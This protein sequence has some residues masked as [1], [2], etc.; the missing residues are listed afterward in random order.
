[1]LQTNNK[2]TLIFVCNNNVNFICF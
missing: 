2:N 1:M